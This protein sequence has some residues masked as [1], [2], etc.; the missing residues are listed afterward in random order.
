[1]IV[2]GIDPSL[3][4]FG[5]SDGERHETY[6]TPATDPLAFRT[7]TLAA[8]VIE[9]VPFG[10]EATWVIEAPS[11][12]SVGHLYEV[13]WL[14]C[15]IYRAASM[16]RATVIEVSPSTLKKFASGK[17]NTK[18]DEMKLKVFRKWGIEFEKDPGADKL[19]AYCL[20]RY[21]MAM[22]AGEIVHTPSA[23]RGS[24]RKKVAA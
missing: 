15:E 3:T 23:P 1:M 12:G 2:I 5:I 17:G 18:K 4:G 20:W 9:F 7:A 19:F 10:H 6:S 8:K 13:G 11:F 16:M 24:K 22:L 21:G 14:M